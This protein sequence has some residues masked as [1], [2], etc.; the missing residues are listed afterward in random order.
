MK[1][2]RVPSKYAVDNGIMKLPDGRE[3]CLDTAAGKREYSHRITVAWVA[4]NQMCALCGKWLDIMDAT[5][6]HK[7]PRGMGGA[8]RDDRQENIQAAHLD[9]NSEKGSQRNYLEAI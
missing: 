2:K 6:D 7:E 5:A 8:R 1:I 3:V 9:C 4:Q